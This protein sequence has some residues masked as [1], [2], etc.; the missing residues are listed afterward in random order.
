VNE[1]RIDDRTVGKGKPALVIAEIGV[2]H[3]GSFAR[4][5]QLVELAA[6]VGAD[7]VKFQVFRADQLLHPSARFAAYQSEQCDDAVPAEMLRRY[8]LPP[9]EIARLATLARQRG[10]LPLATPFSLED[11]D[12]IEHLD[13]P[14]VKIAS[15]DI[16]NRP[17]LERVARLRRPM[18]VSTGAATIDEIARCVAWLR[19]WRTVFALL[20]CV[21]AYP[22]PASEAHLAWIAEL[23]SRFDVPVGYS[24][25]TT[26]VISGALAVA[27]GAC[28]LE[29]HLTY[30]K[31]A[32]GPDHAASSDGPDFAEY[33]R[34][35]RLAERMRGAPGRRVLAIE[36]D[37]RAVSRQS[38]VLR[39][40]VRAGHVIEEADLSVQR[41]GAGI[42]AGDIERVIG[43]R[44]RT[45]LERGAMLQWDML[46]DAVAA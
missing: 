14:A 15:P 26:Q 22:T 18:L 13:L 8:E 32:A 31:S 38:L 11:V 30:D 6:E 28:V 7:A 12:V 42:S 29:R 2:N 35:A 44:A 23:D 43:R 10:L 37:V 20:H 16:V 21:S 33:V 19:E 1:L 25:H 34:L 41:P 5:A 40:D 27:S 39:R 46:T 17:L 9:L 45:L 36:R 3:D 24:D 4:A